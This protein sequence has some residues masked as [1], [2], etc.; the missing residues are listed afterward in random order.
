[1]SKGLLF[2]ILM[3]IWCVFGFAMHAG[4]V[5]GHYGLIG[6]NLTLVVLLV[7]LGWQTFGP[8]IQ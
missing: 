3:L 7:L 6:G 2:W 8:P 1:M 5:G 4:Y